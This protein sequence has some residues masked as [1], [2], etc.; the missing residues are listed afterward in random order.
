MKKL[1][2]EQIISFG[3]CDRYDLDRIKFLMGKKKTVDL[4]DIWKVKLDQPD[5]YLWLVLRPEFISEKQLHQIAIFCW[6]KI[7]C[8]IWEKYYPD[9]KRPHEA[10]RIKKLWLRGK[11]T[12][13]Q[14][15]AARDAAW[16]ATWA[17]A[18]DAAGDAAGAAAWAAAGDAA[19]AA[20]WAAAG[21]A[22]RDAALNKIIKH[23]KHITK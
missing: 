11:A 3:P 19:G 18:G 7:A 12:I 9:D 15:A 16:A 22:A 10:V 2:A 6:D 23:I 8:P 21:A 20:A 13:E 1:T 4:S 14:L 5:D 17:A